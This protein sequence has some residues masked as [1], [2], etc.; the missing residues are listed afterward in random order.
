MN[1]FKLFRTFLIL[2][3]LLLGVFFAISVKRTSAVPLEGCQDEQIVTYDDCMLSGPNRSY[4]ILTCQCT[5]SA[6][7]RSVCLEN[8]NSWDD[9][10]CTCSTN[11][12]LCSDLARVR[13]NNSGRNFIES[14]CQCETAGGAGC[15]NISG[16]VCQASGGVWDPYYC[17][18]SYSFTS[19][20]P[21]VCDPNGQTN[22]E[23][24]GGVWDSRHCKCAYPL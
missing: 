7:A 16:S 5:C 24:A 2:V 8:G 9:G 22:C 1:K 21:P 18:C 4:G 12:Q 6:D 20:M 11:P 3:V 10:T 15:G 19:G 13:C 14:S 17:T 23:N